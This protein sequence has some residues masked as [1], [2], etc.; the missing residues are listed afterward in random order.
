LEVQERS[1]KTELPLG[2]L[3]LDVAFRIPADAAAQFLR[4]P[5]RGV[6]VLTT[7][8]CVG[9]SIHPLRLDP[10]AKAR[11][12]TDIVARVKEFHRPEFPWVG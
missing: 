9:H 7:F 5:Q 4:L 12:S 3:I 11:K 10:K 1:A 6:E 8:G 2:A